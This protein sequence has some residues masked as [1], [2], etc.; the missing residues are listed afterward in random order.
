VASLSLVLAVKQ[1]A[2]VTGDFNFFK[3]SRFNHMKIGNESIPNILH[4]LL[5]DDDRDDCLIFQD[6]LAELLIS[7]H[8]TIV[9]D[10]EQ[11][12]QLLNQK[13]TRLP[14]VIFLDLNMPRKNGFASLEEL[15]QNKKLKH[16]PVVIISTSYEHD[17]VVLLYKN[18][19]QYYICKPT[20]FEDLKQVIHQ[21][22]T[23]LNHLPVVPPS[24][25]NFLL[26]PVETNSL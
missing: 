24:R 13:T 3:L 12:M 7:A 22:L 15:K 1:P 26:Q 2:E 18:G 9:H 8:T 6:A 21:A 5:A 10:G 11:L 25:E 14:D 19:A 23:R 20:S 16:L 17:I 4:I